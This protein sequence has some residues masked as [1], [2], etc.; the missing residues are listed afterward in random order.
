MGVCWA[1]PVNAVP[2]LVG[3]LV[4]LRTVLDAVSGAPSGSAGA[5]VTGEAGIGKSRL[6]AEA[7]ATA[8]ASF[9]TGWCLRTAS[10]LPFL[11][12]VDVLRGLQE[13]DDG[14]RL[15]SALDRCPGFVRDALAILLPELGSGPTGSEVPA[16]GWQRHR[17]FDSVRRVLG[18]VAADTPVVVV[19]EDVH[20]AD[21]S[22]LDLCDYL[23]APGRR[24]SVPVVLSC[25]DDETDPATLETIMNRD[26]L[27]RVPLAPLTRAQTRE[28]LLALVG[29]TIG[30]GHVD[31]V[32]RRAG[33]NAFFTEQLASAADD[34][35]G[36]ALPAG[37]RAVL[38][39]RIRD[40]N[41]DERSVL[42][43]LA[44]S[45][46]AVAEA[47]LT[48][49]C[50]WTEQRV[51]AGVR[52]LADRR[53][54]KVDANGYT[55]RHALLGE[56]V[57]A[58]LLAGERMELHAALA[59]MLATRDDPSLAAVAAEHF[60]GARRKGD[61]LQ[62]RVRAAAHAETVL[63]PAE[64][65]A[66]WRRVLDLW[67]TV[68]DPAGRTGLA[69]SEVY[70]RTST[71]ADLAGQRVE[72][73]ELAEKALAA[74]DSSAPTLHRAQ[75][76]SA[77][78]NLYFPFA[79][80]RG[81]A[82]LREASRLYQTLPPHREHAWALQELALAIFRQGEWDYSEL[83]SLLE[84]TLDIA[85]DCDAP[86][87]AFKTRALLAYLTAENGDPRAGLIQ[88]EDLLSLEPDAA[89]PQQTAGGYAWA[90]S[91]LTFG[92]SR[93]ER[94]VEVGRAALEWIAAHGYFA[95]LQA[96]VTGGNTTIALRELGRIGEASE[97]EE[98][99]RVERHLP[100]TDITDV[101]AL[102]DHAVLASEA[103]YTQNAVKLW[104][105]AQDTLTTVGDT[106]FTGANLTSGV[107]ILIWAD[108]PAAAAR[109]AVEV[110]R[111]RV[112]TYESRE[113]GQTLRLGMRAAADL[114]VR[115]RLRAEPQL[116]VAALEIAAELRDLAT[117]CRWDPFDQP[118]MPATTRC[119]HLEWIAEDGRLGG[120]SDVEAWDEAACSWEQLPAPVRAGYARYRHAEAL[121]AAPG[122]RTAAAESLRQALRSANEHVPL[123]NAICELARRGHLD[124][125]EPTTST[126]PAA[127]A[128]SAP[129]RLA[130]LTA[131]E[132]AVLR[133]VAAGKTNAE[134]GRALFMSPKTASVH[135]TNILRKLQ[136]RSRVQAAAIAAESGLLE[137]VDAAR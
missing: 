86:G 14:A 59:Q 121:L 111:P 34:R 106:P 80:D 112:D 117:R 27:V 118:A 85:A 134:I 67:D 132:L 39:G 73:K 102:V 2:P 110:L 88:I 10:E 92:L 25:R 82:A 104:M 124:L 77:L 44:L 38:L 135:V 12:F 23:L 57:T 97:L 5:L 133:E 107:E 46:R 122:A 129:P 32:Y 84:R 36:A 91:L 125:G 56:A 116:V 48:R 33:G 8:D 114:A 20:W 63:A 66:H 43:V 16:E 93:Y 120:V 103:G 81:A 7:A 15:V 136:I 100:E 101:W 109:L 35:P 137:P 53:L 6:I 94:A 54:V 68:D 51:R 18:A 41:A 31:D 22:T 96:N 37:L 50:G 99:L 64:A 19:I 76:H 70:L 26:G 49:V 47:D 62:W 128:S 98:Q 55:L 30:E 79:L 17:L 60:L 45:D 83:K 42:A 13:L 29:S 113:C 126:A 61:E 52:G 119:D 123:R 72:A 74:C 24:G 40:A 21:S 11:P 108:A 71:A 28:Q 105:L 3:R 130:A 95:S 89:D 78:G 58:G 69:L 75:I 127:G 1:W 131:R 87:V 9:V 90:T 115:G 65:R 4:E